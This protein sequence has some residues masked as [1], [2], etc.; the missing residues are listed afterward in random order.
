MASPVWEGR[1]DRLD[2]DHPG[3]NMA[4][5]SHRVQWGRPC[6]GRNPITPWDLHPQ[7]GLAGRVQVLGE[8]VEAIHHLWLGEEDI[9]QEEA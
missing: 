9:R 8:G 7:V 4:T 1:K 5:L 2:E 6:S 3:I